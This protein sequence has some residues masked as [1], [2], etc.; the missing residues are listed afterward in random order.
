LPGLVVRWPLLEKSVRLGTPRVIC[1]THIV[2]IGGVAAGE[3][4]MLSGLA[5]SGV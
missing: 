1:T 2:E 3:R 4:V 5:Y